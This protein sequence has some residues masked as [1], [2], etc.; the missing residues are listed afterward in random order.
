[1]SLAGWCTMVK[2]GQSTETRNGKGKNHKVTQGR[3]PYSKQKSNYK[4]KNSM[5]ILSRG[6]W[7]DIRCSQETFTT[8]KYQVNKD[9]SI[10]Q[11]HQ[12]LE[13]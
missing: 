13:T 4:I 10:Q 5:L 9:S 6:R 2:T 1:M 3:I 8:G 7:K 11:E 12:G